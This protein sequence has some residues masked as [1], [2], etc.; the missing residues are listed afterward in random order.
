MNS[1]IWLYIRKWLWL[2]FISSVQFCTLQYILFKYN[3]TVAWHNHR[4]KYVNTPFA[5]TR[6]QNSPTSSLIDI[7]SNRSL[8]FQRSFAREALPTLPPV[9]NISCSHISFSLFS[10]ACFVLSR[11]FC[12]HS[13]YS[14]SFN[15]GTKRCPYQ[16]WALKH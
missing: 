8:F 3:S 2:Y 12:A 9:N 13:V 5:F 15:F 4:I 6:L 1:F 10:G 16:Y 11:F 14:D 7:R